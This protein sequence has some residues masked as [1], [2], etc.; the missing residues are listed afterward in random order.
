MG[1]YPLAPFPPT[2]GERG[3]VDALM[4]VYDHVILDA[5][6]LDDMPEQLVATN[7]HA[8]LIAAGLDEATRDIIRKELHGAGFR[9]VTMLDAPADPSHLG[10][11]GGRMAAA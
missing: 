6:S 8:V 11:P 2:E 10:Q 7:A 3:T 9:G 5:G 4:R 1:P